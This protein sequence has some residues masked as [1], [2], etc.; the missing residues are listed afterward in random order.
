MDDVN[1]LNEAVDHTGTMVATHK[2]FP[3][4]A[5]E[6]G[7]SPLSL[8]KLL[9]KSPTSTYFFRVRG[10]TWHRLGVF[11]GDVAIVDRSRSPQE[12]NMVVWWD[13]VGELHIG[14]W[15]KNIGQNVWGTVTATIH[16]F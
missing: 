11:D 6:R 4:P 7:R 12:G 1:L 3:N 2:G 5:A 13:E 14:Q 9:V 16:Q 10:H 8:D 15:H